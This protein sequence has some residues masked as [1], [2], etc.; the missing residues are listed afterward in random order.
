MSASPTVM[1]TLLRS[2]WWSSTPYF[3]QS[4]R[5]AHWVLDDLPTTFPEIPGGHHVLEEVTSVRHEPLSCVLSVRTLE[6]L[7][8]QHNVHVFLCRRRTANNFKG[9]SKHSL[10]LLI[11]RKHDKVCDGVFLEQC[12]PTDRQSSRHASSANAAENCGICH[13]S[14]VDHG[15]DGRNHIERAG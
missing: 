15:P 4:C 8:G 1:N 9:F 11:L 5:K 10:V 6:G 2:R 7:H 3:F 12:V 13:P 14:R